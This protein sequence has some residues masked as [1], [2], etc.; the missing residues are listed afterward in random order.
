VK[1][2][3]LAVVG[4]RALTERTHA[5]ARLR[6]RLVAGGGLTLLVLGFLAAVGL[7][8]LVGLVVAVALAA[9]IVPTAIALLLRARSRFTRPRLPRVSVPEL[10]RVS[11]PRPARRGS[12]RRQAVRLNARGA[13]YRRSGDFGRA[14]QAHSKALALM[15]GIGDRCGEAL[16]L[17]NLALALA[18]GGEDDLA[19]ERFEEALA[20]LRELDDEQREGQ[21]FANLG[22]MH[23]R[24]GRR[25][26]ALGCLQ[27]ALGKLDPGSHEYRRVEE[28]LRRAS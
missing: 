2:E 8:R 6:R 25:E 4:R 20:I 5:G 12:S 9:A 27:V 26:Q 7:G 10:P 24:R 17:N 18:H 3:T 14:L 16:T 1:I 21:V 28:Q 13:A 22:L 23:G 15:R 11:L 19:L